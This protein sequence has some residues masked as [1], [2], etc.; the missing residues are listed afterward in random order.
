MTK[1]RVLVLCFSYFMDIS[2]VVKISLSNKQNFISQK[3]GEF[4]KWEF[5]NKTTF[6]YY[7]F[8]GPDFVK[9][10][11]KEKKNTAKEGCVMTRKLRLV[12]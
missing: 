3:L 9:N 2:N 7:V 10:C 1:L 11:Q 5:A 4:L 6:L 8:Q 12:K